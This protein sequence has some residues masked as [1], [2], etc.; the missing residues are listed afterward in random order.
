MRAM[1]NS[2]PVLLDVLRYDMVAGRFAYIYRI[3]I[4]SLPEPR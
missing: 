2:V 1:R 4:Y 3:A